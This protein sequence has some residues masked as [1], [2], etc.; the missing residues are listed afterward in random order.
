METG[1]IARYTTTGARVFFLMTPQLLLTMVA[2]SYK[3]PLPK[4]LYLWFMWPIW[5]LVSRI[6]FV[7]TGDCG[8]ACDHVEPYGWV[9]EAGCPVHDPED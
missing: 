5:T 6:R 4:R 1:A 9:P 2:P 3:A 8:N 7:L